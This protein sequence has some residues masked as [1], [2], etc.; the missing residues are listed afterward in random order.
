VNIVGK[1]FYEEVVKQGSA[2]YLGYTFKPE[3]FESLMR[4]QPLEQVR[5]FNGDALVVHGTADTEVPVDY[6]FLYQKVFWLRSQGQCDKE[7][8]F[9]ADH[10][11]STAA[12]ANGLF[13]ATLHWLQQSEKRKNDWHDWTI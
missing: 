13:Q 4:H 6:C 10:T 2:D 7:V 3:F 11:Y 8:L 12:A 1:S 9:Q 5:L